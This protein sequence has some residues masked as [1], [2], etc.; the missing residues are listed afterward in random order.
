MEQKALGRP[1]SPVEVKRL[2]SRGPLKENN[3]VMNIQAKL[4]PNS[5]E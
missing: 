3:H 1:R 4:R 5:P 2:D